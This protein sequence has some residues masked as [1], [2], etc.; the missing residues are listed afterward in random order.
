MGKKNKELQLVKKE[1]K[2]EVNKWEIESWEWEL[3]TG[4]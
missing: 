3:K 2:D 4:M 1:P